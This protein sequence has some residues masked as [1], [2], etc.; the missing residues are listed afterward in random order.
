MCLKY[1]LAVPTADIVEVRGFTFFDALLTWP[2]SSSFPLRLA[3]GGFGCFPL[4]VDQHEGM[5]DFDSS[6]LFPPPPPRSE[7]GDCQ[8]FL[9]LF[10]L[11]LQANYHSACFR[12]MV[13][14]PQ[15]FTPTARARI[16]RHGDSADQ[17]IRVVLATKV[18]STSMHLIQYNAPPPPVS[19]SRSK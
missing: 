7:L 8:V 18:L 1:T 16:Y 10:A 12:N 4:W 6:T 15:S 9:F 13:R 3:Q 11:P 19:A 5:I 14:P 2:Q 17:R